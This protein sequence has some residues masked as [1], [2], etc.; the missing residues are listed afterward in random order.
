MKPPIKIILTKRAHD[1]HACIE[2]IPGAWG[3]G[4]SQTEAVG[5]LISA[6]YDTFGVAIM[7]TNGTHSANWPIETQEGGTK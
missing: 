3:C 4:H 1:Y 7:W 2:G 5:N 6:H